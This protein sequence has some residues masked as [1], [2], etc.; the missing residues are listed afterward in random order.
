MQAVILAGGFGTRM[1]PFTEK[2]PK[3][4]LPAGG[5]P[6]IDRQ[7]ELLKAGGVRE[8]LLCLGYLGEMV[9]S[10][11]GDGA[12]RGLRIEYSWD[13]PDS[14]G[15]AGALKHAEPLLDTTFF[16]TWGDSYVRVDHAAM[17]SAHRASLPPVAAT[18]GVFCNQNA[19]DSSNVQIEN[20]KVVRYVKGEPH[21]Q[22]T[23][24]D[25]GIS[26]FER[27]ALVEIP[28]HRSVALDHFF[29]SWAASGRLGAYPVTQRFYEV[30]SWTGLSDFERYI[31]NGGEPPA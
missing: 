1:R 13:S 7:L 16:L 12:S 23:Y 17:F 2:A 31:A 11:L 6:F 21:P 29:S 4:L 10:H 26:V 30:G 19:Y 28:S 27:S 15:T 5:R 3:C 8:I 18:M 22:L 24:I 20:N 9:Q 25:A 14:G